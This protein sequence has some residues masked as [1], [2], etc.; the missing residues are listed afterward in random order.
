MIVKQQIIH[1]DMDAFFASVEQLDDPLLKGKP[2]VVGGKTDQGVVAAASYEARK[3]GIFSAMPTHD[4]VRRCPELIIRPARFDRYKEISKQV[5]EI[6]LEAT[7]L[8][9]PLS[10]DEAYLDITEN[11]L[12]LDSARDVAI[13][14]KTEIKA[15]TGLTASAGVSYNKFLAKMASDMDKP[16][17]LFIIDE[18][19]VEEVLG[20]MPV[21]KFY[22]IGKVTA[23]RMRTLGVHRGKDIRKLSHEQLELYFGNQAKWYYNIS[24]GIDYRK[25]KPHR[26][27]KSVAVERTLRNQLYELP[28]VSEQLKKQCLQL[29]ERLDKNGLSGRSLTLKLK[30]NDFTQITRSKTEL[31]P[32]TKYE[33][34]LSVATQLLEQTYPFK[35]PIRLIGVSMSNFEM[36]E[37]KQLELFI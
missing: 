13:Y 26:K 31:M 22:G 35:L 5:R 17:G 9:E 34:C 33:Q 7:E 29:W 27:T 25:V 6:F 2:I 1:I 20:Q 36:P 19:D 28:E 10:I 37:S 23:E 11:K 4:A 18:G 30:F 16:D 14:I 3:F 8:V 12:D 24:R 32:I 21:N 15:R